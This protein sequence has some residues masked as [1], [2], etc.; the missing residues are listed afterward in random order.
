ME[1]A[2]SYSTYDIEQLK[3]KIDSY[4][5]TLVTLKKGTSLED[6]LVIKNEFDSF[7]KQFWQLDSSTTEKVIQRGQF[8]IYEEQVKQMSSQMNALHQNV[9]EINQE[10]LT[11]F[12]QIIANT[13]S[14]MSTISKPQTPQFEEVFTSIEENTPTQPPVLNKQPSFMQLQLIA[15]KANLPQNQPLTTVQEKTIPTTQVMKQFNH[16]K[17][18]PTS[19][20]P[21]K[22]YNGLFKNAGK[23][24]TLQFKN[25][26]DYQRDPSEISVTKT[27]PPTINVELPT[28]QAAVDAVPSITPFNVQHNQ[29][30]NAE[31]RTS[32]LQETTTSSVNEIEKIAAINPGFTEYT[33]EHESSAASTAVIEPS[34]TVEPILTDA[35][36]QH[37]LST[38]STA[39]IEPSDTVEPILTDASLQHESSAAST[40]V[41]EPSD[42][43]EPILTD[44]SLQHEPSTASTAVI[45]PSDAVDLI[46]TDASS[47]EQTLAVTDTTMPN[48]SH[49]LD[50]LGT[51]TSIQE[52]FIFSENAKLAVSQN[53]ELH[54]IDQTASSSFKQIPIQEDTKKEKGNVFLNLFR[55]KN[56]SFF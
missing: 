5:Q 24:P 15:G 12:K 8:E 39:V 2:K 30:H 52:E 44:A 26:L 29:E 9:E 48:T 16:Q 6:C 17:F 36:L 35:S 4:K 47:Q 22:M 7:K 50:T 3:Q 38:A 41:I 28:Q 10:I 23:E 51:Q 46:S 18:H 13:E 45:E 1:N 11:I 54:N 25:A 56:K 20:P 32:I 14:K 19:T 53:N 21:T 33:L 55:R 49:H 37:E 27:F 42:T 40:A 31:S 43:V 34:D